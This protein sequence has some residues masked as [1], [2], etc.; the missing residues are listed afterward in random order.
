MIVNVVE[1]APA[2]IV[3]EAGGTA[4]VV[5]EVMATV[6]PPVGAGLEIVNV[7]TE[8][9]PPIKVVGLSDSDDIVGAVIPSVAFRL[10][11]FSAAAI[12]DE[13]EV[14][15]ANVVTANVADVVP[16]GTVTDVG[17]VAFGLLDCNE[18]T[19]PEPPG[20][21]ARVTV[22]VDDVPP[23]TDVGLSVRLRSPDG[24]IVSSA[25]WL[26]PL[27]VP[28]MVTLVVVATPMV[29]I[30]NV[31][32]VEPAATVTLAGTVAFVLF[33]CNATTAPPAPA[34]PERVTVPVDGVPLG[35]EVGLTVTLV[36]VAGVT[37]RVAV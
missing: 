34:G 14:D 2:G 6:N 24:V 37:V 26:V 5:D 31:A 16:A 3:T 30:V 36:S 29:L 1:V 15:T 27:S 12:V 20:A 23:G 19:A 17:T 11:P 33:D 13:V 7:P 28:V 4:F 8:L 18:T 10:A 25:F 21:L 32:V 9:A 35:T 22:P